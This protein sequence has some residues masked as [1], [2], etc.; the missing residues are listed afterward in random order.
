LDNGVPR[1]RKWGL[2]QQ[3]QLLTI[4]PLSV[5]PT[6]RSFLFRR[7]QLIIL[8]VGLLT[9]RLRAAPS[10]TRQTRAGPA[11][12]CARSRENRPWRPDIEETYPQARRAVVPSPNVPAWPKIKRPKMKTLTKRSYGFRDENFFILK[13][14]SLHHSKYKLLG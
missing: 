9:A 10:T 7:S 11:G 4:Q 3:N 6:Q 13:L 12:N 5:H 8:R 14:L 2:F 1:F